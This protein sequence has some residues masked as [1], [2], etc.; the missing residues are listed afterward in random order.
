M[1]QSTEELTT[2]IEHTRRDLSRDLDALHERVSPHQVMARRKQAT[3][4]K[5]HSMKEKVMGS[6]HDAKHSASATGS[7]AADSVSGTAQQA[8]GTVEQKTEGNPL[9]AGLIAFGTGVLISSLIPASRAEAQA[10]QRLVEQAKEHGQPVMDEAKT[11]GQQMGQDLK[12]QAG[13]AAQ[14]VKASAQES[15]RNVQ[16][17]GQSSAQHVKDDTQ[18]RM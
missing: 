4:S 1:G 15:A 12:D 5:L 11:A 2:D 16:S 3:R 9:A 18:Q 7:S 6:A 8:V 17:E 13:Q 10:A 14:E